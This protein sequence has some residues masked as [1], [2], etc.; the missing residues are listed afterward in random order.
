MRRGGTQYAFPYIYIKD[1]MKSKFKKFLLSVL[2]LLIIAVGFSFYYV[3]SAG[4][5]L[6]N[7][8]DKRINIEVV[9]GATVKTISDELEKKGVIK[10]SFAL[11]KLLSSIAINNSPN[12]IHPV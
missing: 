7:K 2:V 5:P 11:G 4:K 6:D 9:Q 3:H 8:S 10:S 1:N 12:L